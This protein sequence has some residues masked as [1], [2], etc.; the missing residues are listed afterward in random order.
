M[1]LTN[2]VQAQEHLNQQLNQLLTQKE[3]QMT[4]NHVR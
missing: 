2:Q 1:N 4:T 3:I